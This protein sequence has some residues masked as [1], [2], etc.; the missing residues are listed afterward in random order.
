MNYVYAHC[1]TLPQN[2]QPTKNVMIEYSVE[3]FIHDHKTSIHNSLGQLSLPFQVE[4]WRSVIQFQ[5]PH[6]QPELSIF[7]VSMVEGLEEQDL[8]LQQALKG[9]ESVFKFKKYTCVN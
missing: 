9:T 2:P 7:L 6:L 4:Q 5:Q 8:N 1:S 3:E